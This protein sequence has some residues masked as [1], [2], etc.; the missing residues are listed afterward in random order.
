MEANH[1]CFI[2]DH[3]HY[4]DPVCLLNFGVAQTGVVRMNFYSWLQL[5]L[6]IVVLLVLAKPLGSFMAKVYQGEHTIL[7]RV[8]GPWNG[9]FIA[10]QALIQKTK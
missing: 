10:C 9:S 4:R 5:I 2:R 7:D 1:E 3:G 8:L 6:Y